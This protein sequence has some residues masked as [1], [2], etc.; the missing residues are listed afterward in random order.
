[1]KNKFSIAMSLAVIL[2]MLLTSFALADVIDGDTVASG[3][4]TADLGIVSPGAVLQ[5]EV[6]FQLLCTNNKHVDDPQSVILTFSLPGS[7]VPAGGSLS[8]TN[9]SIGNTSG[10][11]LGVPSSWPDDASGAPNCGSTAA[12]ND[13]G[14]STVT[15][16][17]PMV[18]G[19]YTY[20]VHYTN[21]L[22][23]AGSNDSASITAASTD[24]TFTLTVVA[25]VTDADGDGVVDNIDNCP[26]VANPLQTD[27]DHDGLGDACDD[28]SY[29]PAVATAADDANG[30][31]GDTLQTSGA[32]SDQDG[33]DTLTITKFSGDGTVIDNG[34]GTWSWSLA[35]VDDSSGTVVVQADDGEHAVAMDSFDWSATNVAP[36]I[37][38]FT[39]TVP[40]GAA[41]QGATNSVGVSFTVSDPADE[42]HDPITG[43]ITWGDNATTPISGRTVSE[44]HPYSAGIWSLTVSV[45]DGDGGS[46]SDTGAVS[47]LYDTSGILQ[48]INLT[49]TRSSFKIGSTIPVKI[50]VTDCGG[51]P[52]S[53]LT[54]T[55]NLALVDPTAVTVNELVSSSAAD[56]GTTMR[57]TGAPDNLYIFNLSTKRSQFNAGQ[58]LIMGTYHVWITGVGIAQADAYFDARK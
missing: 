42:A 30:N 53:G 48:P 1:M 15:I 54:L 27:S 36:I 37:N 52:V 49:G 55:V 2:A 58:D 39:I 43:T 38:D 34:D 7:T 6:T 3:T 56:L 14:N 23:S 10:L 28:N 24:I 8:A 19:P 40:T 5:P 51:A 35:T 9:T 47:L 16:T 45:N 29:V 13:N 12:L 26:A 46:D 33:N 50:K 41:C 18:E 22:S 4:A 57:F 21:S 25:P 44:S 11:D 20:I 17:A 32:F 31:E